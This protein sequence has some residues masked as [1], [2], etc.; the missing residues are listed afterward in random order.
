MT[1]AK[2]QMIHEEIA[3]RMMAG[4]PAQKLCML[5]LPWLIFVF[6]LAIFVIYEC[7]AWTQQDVVMETLSRSSAIVQSLKTK[8]RPA[9][10][11]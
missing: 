5:G 10:V 1:V 6:T 8:G 9:N 11:A 4:R 3:C 2:M 7:L